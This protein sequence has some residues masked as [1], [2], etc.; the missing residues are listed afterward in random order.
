MLTADEV[1][2]LAR[3]TEGKYRRVALAVALLLAGL[4]TLVVSL[5]AMAVA[6]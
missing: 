5:L 6:S 3:I 1:C 2:I 4:A